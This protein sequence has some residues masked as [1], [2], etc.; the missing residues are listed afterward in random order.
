M[1]VHFAAFWVLAHDMGLG[2][3]C[4]HPCTIFWTLKFIIDKVESLDIAVFAWLW[5]MAGADLL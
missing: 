3:C 2:Q 4:F 1:E 5:L